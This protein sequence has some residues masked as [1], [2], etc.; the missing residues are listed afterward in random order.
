MEFLYTVTELRWI[1]QAL[2]WFE[3]DRLDGSY[4]LI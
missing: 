1:I 2:G 3:E 4:R